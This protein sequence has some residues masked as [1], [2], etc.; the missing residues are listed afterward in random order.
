MAMARRSADRKIYEITLAHIDAI[1]EWLN[2]PGCLLIPGEKWIGFW[3]EN[4]EK[5]KE[6]MKDQFLKDTYAVSIYDEKY[7]EWRA[8][9]EGAA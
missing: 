3:P 2:D 4:L 5:I 7:P 9:R 6:V 8:E 1:E